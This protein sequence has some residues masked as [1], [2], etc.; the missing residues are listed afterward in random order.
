MITND[1]F[2]IFI[3]SHMRAEKVITYKTLIKAN[4]TG[5]IYIIIDNEDEQKNLYLK[6][7]GDK[8][9]IFDK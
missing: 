8:V 6:K 5:K 2:A 9:I 1:N 3:L 7:F 4:Y